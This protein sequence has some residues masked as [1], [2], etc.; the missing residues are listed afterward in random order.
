MSLEYD[1]SPRLAEAVKLDVLVRRILRRCAHSSDH[2]VAISGAR[3]D[4]AH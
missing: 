3:T 1:H 4:A 2:E